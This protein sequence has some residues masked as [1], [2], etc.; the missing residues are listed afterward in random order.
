VIEFK[1]ENV[2]DEVY[3]FRIFV[4]EWKNGAFS[5]AKEKAPNPWIGHV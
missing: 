4:G 1:E 2:P 5:F 3:S